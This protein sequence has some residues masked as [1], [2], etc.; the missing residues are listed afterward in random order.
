MMN[1]ILIIL[2]IVSFSNSYGQQN[3]MSFERLKALKM[4]YI[5]EKIGLSEEEESVFWGIY[6]QYEKRIFNNC[7]KEIKKIRRTYMKSLDN[8]TNSEA[9]E[10]IHKI[11]E[12]EHDGLNLKEERDKLLLEKFSA[13]KIL[14]M[15]HAEYHFNREMLYKMKKKK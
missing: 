2:V 4:S 3:K 15:H 9:L 13:Q 1:R 5:T 12:L 10:I 14:K 6:D 11:N 8:V 7:R